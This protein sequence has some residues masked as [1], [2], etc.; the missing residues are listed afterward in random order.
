M[1]ETNVAL[2]Y[3][4]AVD[5]LYRTEIELEG[6]QGENSSCGRDEINSAEREL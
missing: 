3:K 1:G 2:D 4:K 6:S 5:E